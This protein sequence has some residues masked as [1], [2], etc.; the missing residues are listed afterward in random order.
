MSVL[1]RRKST[2]WARAI[3]GFLAVL[4]MLWLLI[5]SRTQLTYAALGSSIFLIL[6]SLCFTFTVL[7]GMHATADS[8]SE[9]KRE[10]TLG[11]L[12]LTDLKGTDIVGG[13]LAATSLHA[14]LAL[15]GVIPM[16]S[17]ALLLGGV[18]LEQF[19]RVALVLINTMFFS[20]ALGVFVSSLSKNERKAMGGTFLGLGDGNASAGVVFPVVCRMGFAP[21]RERSAVSAIRGHAQ[22]RKQLCVRARGP[23]ATAPGGVAGPKCIS[24]ARLARTGEAE[25]RLGR[26]FVFCGFVCLDRVFI[27]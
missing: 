16:L 3:T 27:R 8:L 26:A 23:T 7:V 21:L 15:I 14:V 20:L 10:G 6:S 1:A 24:V 18:T 17:I 19:G 4:V 13:K 11:L 25:I 2:Y 5:V 12:F 9:E 22:F